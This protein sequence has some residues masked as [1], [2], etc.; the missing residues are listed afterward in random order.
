MRKFG[1]V[2][3]NQPQIIRE[4]REAYGPDCAFDLSSV[5]KGIPDQLLGIQGH[6]ILMEIKTDTGKLTPDQVRF[7]RYWNGGPLMVARCMADV[8]DELR[9]LN[10]TTFLPVRSKA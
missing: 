5:G 3:A 7:H 9:R 4:L 10:A 8:V 6:T 1:R 2:D